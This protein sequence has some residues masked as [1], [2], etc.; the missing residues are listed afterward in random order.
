MSEGRR[1]DPARAAGITQM[2][3]MC[4][5]QP[6]TKS[7]LAEALHISVTALNHWLYAAQKSNRIYY[8]AGLGWMT[9]R[10][11]KELGTLPATPTTE[12]ANVP[13]RPQWDSTAPVTYHR[14]GVMHTVCPAR[15]GPF[16]ADPAVR[17]RGAISADWMARR[18]GVA[19]PSR[20][21]GL[22]GG[23]AAEQPINSAHLVGIE[24]LKP[25]ATMRTEAA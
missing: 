5:T 4:D 21:P 17:G 6:Q 19:V 11:G 2:V 23:P 3:Q 18:Q 10:L 20:V 13:L 8:R 25:I 7:F 15:R 9:P 12:T 22:T 1:P 16:E 24:S 14:D